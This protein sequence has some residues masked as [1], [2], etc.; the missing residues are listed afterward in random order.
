MLWMITIIIIIVGGIIQVIKAV[1]AFVIST[2][3]KW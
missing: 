2:K 3:T 1:A